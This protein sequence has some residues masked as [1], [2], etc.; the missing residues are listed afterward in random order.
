MQG[1]E[2]TKDIMLLDKII[3]YLYT[4]IFRILKNYEKFML[5]TIIEDEKLIIAN[6]RL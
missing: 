1:N 6:K 3:S 5:I 2:Q 4:F